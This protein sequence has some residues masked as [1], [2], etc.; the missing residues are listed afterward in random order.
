MSGSS[1]EPKNQHLWTLL[2]SFDP[3]VDNVRE[4]VEKVKFLDAICPEK[5]RPMLAP[6]LAM[7]CKGTAWGQVKAL[8]PSK[9]TDQVNG[10]KNL[11]A[12]LAS[13]EESAEMKTY[14]LF[15]KAMYKINQKAD[16]SATSYVKSSSSG[17]GR[18]WTSHSETV[19]CVL[20]AQ[21]ER[22]VTRGQEEGAD[23]DSRWDG[24]SKGGAG[25]EDSCNFSV[26]Y[27]A[28]EEGLPHQFCGDRDA[29]R[30]WEPGA[31]GVLCQCGGGGHLLSGELGAFGSSGDENALLIQQFEKD[32]E[33]MMQDIPELQSALLSYQD[34]RQRISDRRRHR[35]FW[36]SRGKGKGGRDY[37]KGPRKGG[38]RSGKEELL[39][40]IART[41]CKIC[42]AVGHWKAECPRRN[43]SQK[44]QA[45]FVLEE[46]D[47]HRDLLQVHYE[48]SDEDTLGHGESCFF[49]H[50]F[51]S[52]KHPSKNVIP[53]HVQSQAIQFMSR[54]LSRHWQNSKTR[55]INKWDNGDKLPAKTMPTESSERTQI[56]LNESKQ[57]RLI[58]SFARKS[59]TFPNRP[60]MMAPDISPTEPEQ[61]I[62]QVSSQAAANN[63]LAI[64][65]TGASRSVIGAEH[66]PAVLRKLPENVRSRVREKPSRIGFRFGNNQIA[67]SFKQLQIP[68][69]QGKLK[70]WLLVEVVPKSNTF[71]AVN[72]S[73]EEF[74]GKNWFGQWNM[75]SRNVETFLAIEGKCHRSLCDRCCW[76]V[77]W[78]NWTSCGSRPHNVKWA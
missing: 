1:E 58:P 12:A 3:A 67:Y 14:E 55:D 40:R 29:T 44:E 71:S 6:R 27:W 31:S 37:G 59:P 63:G 26:V 41:H 15:E 48:L 5:D 9:L 23:H 33:D 56:T 8:E 16:E 10:V 54:R 75:L 46:G 7:L 25:Y 38:H 30:W 78:I 45:N 69:V 60:T 35:G 68:L 11:L 18:A 47:D 24:D 21:A 32:F 65:D 53:P 28:Q 42:G 20:T 19:P 49:V 50:S 22:I 70:I 61:Q 17:N 52:N 76:F 36:P 43:E 4:Y 57:T 64:L 13:W 74:G 73:N 34:A 66:V 51:S 77:P 62:N 2:P 72:Q 39:A